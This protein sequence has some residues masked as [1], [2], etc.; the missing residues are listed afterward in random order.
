MFCMPI[1]D[2]LRCNNCGLCLMV[3]DCGAFSL[4]GNV[5]RVVETSECGYCTDCEA[6]CPTGAIQCPYEVI[7]EEEYQISIE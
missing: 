4:V 5:V 7:I 1:L 3:C 6:I 2:S